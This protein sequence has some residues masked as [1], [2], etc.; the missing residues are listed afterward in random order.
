MALVYGA[1]YVARGFT[2]RPRQLADLIAGGIRHKGF[3]LIEIL[4]NCNTYYGRPNKISLLE[5]LQWEKSHT[6]NVKAAER[7]TPQQLE[8]KVLTGLLHQ[9]ERP[10][11]TAQYEE[12]IARVQAKAAAAPR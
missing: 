5:L 7:M 8:G 10:E 11:Y 12:L 3:A 4:E 1:T 9:A 2:G 6:V